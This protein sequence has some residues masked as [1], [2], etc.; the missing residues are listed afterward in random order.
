MV[1]EFIGTSKYGHVANACDI[2]EV[3]EDLAKGVFS[4]SYG[5]NIDFGQ[6]SELFF[7]LPSLVASMRAKRRDKDDEDEE[8]PSSLKDWKSNLIGTTTFIVPSDWMN[9]ARTR[10]S[11]QVQDR[12]RSERQKEEA[13]GRTP[14]VNKWLSQLQGNNEPEIVD[15][16][17]DMHSPSYGENFLG[18]WQ[19][20]SP[21]DDQGR[22]IAA[23]IPQSEFATLEGGEDEIFFGC[24]KIISG[25]VGKATHE[26][27]SM[28]ELL[29]KYAA[30]FI[31]IEEEL[32]RNNEPDWFDRDE[33]HDAEPEVQT[34]LRKKLDE[35]WDQ[36]TENLLE[37]TLERLGL[38]EHVPMIILQNSLAEL[39]EWQKRSR[40]EEP[41]IDYSSIFAQQ[42]PNH[43]NPWSV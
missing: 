28:R 7:Q 8:T 11:K 35:H 5:K 25:A 6:N 30:C 43:D 26:K 12:A 36:L 22:E 19:R 21:G 29:S 2:A 42:F 18:A 40:G 23:L 27:E 37:S 20:C 9:V 1:I 31:Y 24:A 17:F 38:D 13:S 33:F 41:K 14:L 39:D 32:E 10:V 3:F 16:T 4:A 15:A 34:K